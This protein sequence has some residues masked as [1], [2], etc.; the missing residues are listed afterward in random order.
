LR[1]DIPGY[2][3]WKDGELVAK[4]AD[5]R[6]WWRDDL[7]AF[8]IGCSFT[9]EAALVRAGLPPRHLSAGTTVPMYRTSVPLAS[10]G[11]LHGRLV[12]S[13]RPYPAHQIDRVRAVTRPFTQGHGE[14]FWAGD[15]GVLG[16]DDLNAPDEGDPVDVGP[17]EVPVFWG[18]GVTPQLVAIE[19]RLPYAITHEP[20]MMF[21]TDLPA[22]VQPVAVRSPSAEDVGLA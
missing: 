12:V 21:I 8:L 18:C 17:G 15:P 9:F 19:S 6:A 7:G 4:S 5:A 14:P 11:R 13:M 20:G 22:G 16:I 2:R 1:T 3:L 10:A